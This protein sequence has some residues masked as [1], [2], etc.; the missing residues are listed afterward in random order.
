MGPLAAT[1]STRPQSRALFSGC[2]FPLLASCLNLSKRA[3]KEGLTSQTIT[4]LSLLTGTSSVT[5]QAL[6]E[7]TQSATAALQ[8]ATRPWPEQ[9]SWASQCHTSRAEGH[10]RQLE[11]NQQ[12]NQTEC[13]G[14]KGHKKTEQEE[15]GS[16]Q[17]GPC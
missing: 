13:Q 9:T 10:S 14:A 5:G 3:G 4:Q 11:H 15:A 6:T 1:D 7:H 2:G 16:G 12:G 17:R 8:L